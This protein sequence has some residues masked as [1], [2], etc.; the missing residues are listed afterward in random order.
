MKMSVEDWGCLVSEIEQRFNNA[1]IR[2]PSL[3]MKEI[4]GG[5]ACTIIVSD[6]IWHR[7]VSHGADQSGAFL[8][9]TTVDRCSPDLS[10]IEFTVCGSPDGWK[11]F[12]TMTI[13]QIADALKIIQ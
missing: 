10:E 7:A 4:A 5:A 12:K 11:R 9:G 1:K 8:L 6:G 2:K 3:K 13:P